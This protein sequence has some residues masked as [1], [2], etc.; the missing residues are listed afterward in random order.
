MQCPCDTY[1]DQAGVVELA[2]T[3]DLKSR[4][5][6]GSC[7]FKSRPRHHVME[8]FMK[9]DI[10]WAWCFTPIRILPFH[11]YMLA[12]AKHPK[13][14]A[15][16]RLY[17]LALGSINREFTHQASTPA[18]ATKTSRIGGSTSRDSSPNV[19]R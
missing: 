17:Y 13:S 19:S 4:G 12:F 6:Q 5:P 3:R 7:G 10:D 18:S 15:F 14:Q 11:R 16:K 2:D 9:E 1:V 8:Q